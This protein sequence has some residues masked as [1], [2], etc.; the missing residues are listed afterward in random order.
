MVHVVQETKKML[1]ANYICRPAMSPPTLQV[2]YNV[3]EEGKRGPAR[4][5]RQL[6]GGPW[7]DPRKR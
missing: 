6:Q 4:D 5:V 2:Q 7:R 3:V 1:V